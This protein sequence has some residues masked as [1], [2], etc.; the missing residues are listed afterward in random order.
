MERDDGRKGKEKRDVDERESQSNGSDHPMQDLLLLLLL[1]LFLLT[2][3]I[4]EFIR[5][6]VFL[7]ITSKG[8]GLDGACGVESEYPSLSSGSDV[9]D[10]P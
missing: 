1:L 4:K 10:H 7:K 2:H 8:G 9:L 3:A 6:D 5:C